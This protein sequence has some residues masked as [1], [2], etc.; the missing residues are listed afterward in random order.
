MDRLV[1]TNHALASVCGF[2]APCAK[3]QI[4]I[5]TAILPMIFC[6]MPIVALLC[7]NMGR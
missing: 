5:S 6:V 1:A 7:S 3:P 4:S 2:S